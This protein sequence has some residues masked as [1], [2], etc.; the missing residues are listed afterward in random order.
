MF[1]K[2][3]KYFILDTNVLLEDPKSVLKFEDNG[4]VLPIMVLEELDKFKKGADEKARNARTVSR[5]LDKLKDSKDL[6]KGIKING[7]DGKLYVRTLTKD[8]NKIFELITINTT[9]NVND[10]MIIATALFYQK[11]LNK[12]TVLVTR[13]SNMRIRAR[14]LGLVAQDYE[15]EKVNYEEIYT[16]IKSITISDHSVIK[17]IYNHHFFENSIQD[18]LEG[19]RIKLYP[20]QFLMINEGTQYSAITQ[21]TDASGKL[22]LLTKRSNFTRGA[23][24]ITAR[25]MRQKLAFELLLDK[26]I[27]L[28]SL[29]GR[30]GTGKTLMAIASGLKMTLDDGLYKGLM[31]AR[32][33]VPMGGYKNDIG[34]LPGDKDEKLSE[35]MQPIYDNLDFIFDSYDIKELLGSKDKEIH[36]KGMKSYDYLKET[37]LLRVEALSFI[38]GRSIPNQYMIIDEAQNLSKHELKT[39]IS[40]AGE[41]TKIV[42]TGDPDQIDSP[43]LDAMSCGL[44]YVVEHLKG[45]KIAGSILLDK[46]ERSELANIASR[47]L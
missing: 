17:D 30:A 9:Q 6:A 13:D 36:A 10:N 2:P 43:Y 19:E 3:S 24:G 34:F 45:E 32:P 11:E 1:D 44:S 20:N 23:F 26:D 35:W 14:A 18:R 40:R 22:N 42:L 38:R 39:I 15:A 31:I 47:L 16:G 5:M 12:N 25:N 21:V 28:V 7:K 8:I 27:K 4:V 37:G 29:I 46:G 41:G 33:V